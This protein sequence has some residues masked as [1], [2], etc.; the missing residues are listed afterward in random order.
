[1]LAS[2][3]L[4]N[5][6]PITYI[7]LDIRKYP[8]L[9]D[10]F[11]ISLILA[12]PRLLADVLI[13]IADH[14]IRLNLNA[15]GRNSCFLGKFSDSGSGIMDLDMYDFTLGFNIPLGINQR[16]GIPLVHI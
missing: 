15:K 14:Q 1:M 10:P 5:I 13:S 16:L 2:D 4:G 11:F 3:R 7:N 12:L 8:F 6:S 9:P